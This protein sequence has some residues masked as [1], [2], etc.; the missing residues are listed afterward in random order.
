[1]YAAHVHLFKSVAVSDRRAK[2]ERK[3]LETAIAVELALDGKGE[4]RFDTKVPFLEHMLEQIARH[5][6]FDLDIHCDGDVHIDDHH[7]VEDIGITLGQAFAKALGE[8]KGITRYGHAYVS[9]TA[10]PVMPGQP[11]TWTSFV[12]RTI[13]TRLKRYSRLLGGRC[14]W[15]AVS[16]TG[17]VTACHRRKAAYS[18]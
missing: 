8:R 9:L 2:V 4:C 13:I 6:L 15:L 3:T 10:L 16:M 18:G 11:C 7:S 14:A 1:V 17:Q 5:G 12:V